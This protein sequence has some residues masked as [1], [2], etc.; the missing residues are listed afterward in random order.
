MLWINCL[1]SS[2]PLFLFDSCRSWFDSFCNLSAF[3]ILLFTSSAILFLVFKGGRRIYNFS[4]NISAA[5]NFR[6]ILN[7]E[8]SLLIHRLVMSSIHF[9]GRI[10]VTPPYIQIDKCRVISLEMT[11]CQLWMNS[12]LLNL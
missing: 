11:R 3:C 8:F 5:D 6:L 9:N 12:Y 7:F 10:S 1:K 2:S 4:S